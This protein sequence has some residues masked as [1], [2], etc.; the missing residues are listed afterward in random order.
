ME[1]KHITLHLEKIN[2]NSPPET[3][4]R[5]YPQNKLQT[6]LSHEPCMQECN[7]N[8]NVNINR[9]ISTYD[10]ILLLSLSISGKL[11]IR[12]IVLEFSELYTDGS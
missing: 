7:I 9:I 6:S 11:T 4:K 8:Q 3:L 10:N 5:S 12:H 1:G 2:S